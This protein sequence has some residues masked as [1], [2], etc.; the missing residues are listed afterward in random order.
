M[1]PDFTSY[2]QSID[3]C[4]TRFLNS[5]KDTLLRINSLGGKSIDILDTFTRRG[6]TIRGSLVLALALMESLVLFAF[7]IAILLQGP[8]GAAIGTVK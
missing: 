1:P 5:Q 3:E 7:L 6:K 8:I 2:K 4:I